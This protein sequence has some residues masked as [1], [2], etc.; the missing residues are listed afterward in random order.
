VAPGGKKAGGT[1]RTA[2][3][4][5]RRRLIE[6]IEDDGRYQRWRTSAAGYLALNDPGGPSVALAD[7][8]AGR[9]RK[10]PIVV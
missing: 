9:T 6:L 3:G 2:A 4:L 1:N 10:R 7:V 5:Q 8:W